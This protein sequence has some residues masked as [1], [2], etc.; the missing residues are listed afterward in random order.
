MSS[1]LDQSDCRHCGRCEFGGPGL[2]A[3]DGKGDVYRVRCFVKWAH[4]ADKSQAAGEWRVAY[5]ELAGYEVS[6]VFLGR[7]FAWGRGRPLL[8]ETS[9]WGPKSGPKYRHYE[10]WAAAVAGHYA[11]VASVERRN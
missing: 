7:D 11:T 8:F 6:T 1:G 9:A 5:D 2:Y 3:L 4:W 10:T